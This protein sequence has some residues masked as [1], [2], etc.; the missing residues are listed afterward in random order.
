MGQTEVHGAR[1]WDRG[2]LQG[3]RG[4]FL[5]KDRN[6]DADKSETCPLYVNQKRDADPTTTDRG[7][8]GK[9]NARCEG[10]LPIG[11]PSAS[12]SPA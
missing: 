10:R 4:R 9:G 2:F 1:P 7:S 12:V 5:G 11:R 6:W 8:A 3:R